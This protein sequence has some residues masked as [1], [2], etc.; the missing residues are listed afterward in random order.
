MIY[1]IFLPCRQERLRTSLPPVSS[2]ETINPPLRLQPPPSNSSCLGALLPPRLHD[3]RSSNLHWQVLRAQQVTLF[4]YSAHL[5]AR[6]AK[7]PQPVVRVIFVAEEEGLKKVRYCGKLFIER[8]QKCYGCGI[9]SAGR[10]FGAD[11]GS[12]ASTSTPPPPPLWFPPAP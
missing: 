8:T 7:R 2:P 11:F 4:L 1:C 12:T 5:D 10:G 9:L 6:P 3:V